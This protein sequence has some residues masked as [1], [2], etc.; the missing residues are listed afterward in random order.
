MLISGIQRAA[1]TKC[2]ATL[3]VYFCVPFHGFISLPEKI[4]PNTTKNDLEY[5][6]MELNFLTSTSVLIRVLETQLKQ[7]SLKHK[8]SYHAQCK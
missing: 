7:L 1:R 3:R 6:F 4:K 5:F 8:E 2:L